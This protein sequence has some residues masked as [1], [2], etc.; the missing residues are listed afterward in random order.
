MKVS[1]FKNRFYF[2]V[3]PSINIYA[4]WLLEISW[5]HITINIRR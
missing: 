3:I 1:V 4:W 5:L 2:A